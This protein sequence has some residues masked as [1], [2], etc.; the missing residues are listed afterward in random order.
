VR[1]CFILP[2]LGSGLPL[3]GGMNHVE[4]N[5]GVLRGDG[6]GGE[7]P[8]AP[9]CEMFLYP[10]RHGSGTY[11]PIGYKWRKNGEFLIPHKLSLLVS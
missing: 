10:P 3:A 5:G 4:S 1:S 8:P 7:P 2:V 6:D 11:T 9:R